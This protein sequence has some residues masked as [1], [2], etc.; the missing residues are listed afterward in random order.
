MNLLI[1]SLRLIASLMLFHDVI[2]SHYRGGI[3]MLRP[4]DPQLSPTEMEIYFR[5]SWRRSSWEGGNCDQTTIDSGTLLSS[6]SIDCIAGCTG[7]VMSAQYYCTDFSISDD[8]SFGERREVFTFSPGTQNITIAY[9]GCCWVIASSWNT[10]TTMSLVP[11]SDTGTINSTPRAITSLNLRLL[12]GCNHTIAIPV[13][14]PDNDI[15]RCRWATGS[16]ECGSVCNAFPN[17]ILDE[18]YCT[19]S[20][21]AIYGPGIFAV[22]LMIEDFLPGSNSPISSVALQFMV[23]VFTSNESCSSVPEFIPPTLPQ[24][25]CVAIPPNSTFTGQLVAYSGSP[26]AQVIEINTIS[27]SGFNKSGLFPAADPDVFYVNVSW[28]PDPSQYNEVHALCYIAINSLGLSSEQICIQLSAGDYAPYIIQSSLTPANNE[29]IPPGIT[30]LHLEFSKPVRPPTHDASMYIKDYY[31]DA[32]LYEVNFLNSTEVLIYNDSHVLI[33]PQF[34][35]QECTK[36]YIVF[37]KGVVVG[38]GCNLESEPVTDK[39]FWV[40]TAECMTTTTPK[41]IETTT[42]SG[43]ST[44]ENH[45]CPCQDDEPCDDDDE[46][47]CDCEPCEDDNPCT[48]KECPCCRKRKEGYVNIENKA[49]IEGPNNVVIQNIRF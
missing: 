37:D 28:T 12:A 45:P 11:R 10:V 35:I 24:G 20:Y 33:T 46:C 8:W 2:A 40:L 41:E 42:E 13:T 25:T 14:D 32:V 16:N 17:A 1:S 6:G 30:V 15:V 7:S 21:E 3:I 5:V 44:E 23:E 27:P 43:P 19:L 49:V 18:E 29:V 9:T 22:A 47:S 34:S 26:G 48:H 38:Y 4:T 31:T 39:D 36:V